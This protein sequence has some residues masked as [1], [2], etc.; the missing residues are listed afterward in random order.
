MSEAVLRVARSSK[1]AGED[2]MVSIIRN[3]QIASDTGLRNTFT[4]IPAR[5]AAPIFYA[6]TMVVP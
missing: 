6:P 5:N 3:Q 2:L 1:F 4:F